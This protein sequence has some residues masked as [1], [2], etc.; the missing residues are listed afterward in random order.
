MIAPAAEA[1]VLNA[2]RYAQ[3]AEYRHGDRSGCLKGTRSTALD[4]IELWTRNFHEPPVYWL[5]GL[6]GTGKTTIAQTVTE[7]LFADGRLGASFFC[8]RD[9]GDRRDLKFIFP[10]LAVQL[11]RKY[12]EFRSILL[13]LIQADPDI[14]HESLYGQMKKLIV[15][16]LMGS[17]IST[18]IV[19]DALDECKDD[20]PASAILSVLGQFVTEIPKVKFFVTGRPEPRIQKSFRLPLL[21]KAT[22]VLVLH[23]VGSGQVNRDIQLF[24]RHNFSEL[25]E[26]QGGLDGWPTEEDLSLLCERAAGFFVYATATIRFV[27]QK[28]KNPKKQLGRLLQSPESGFEGR[29]KLKEGA[30]LDSLYLSILQEAFCDYDPEDGPDVRS[31][32]GAVILATVPLSPSTIAAL[33]GFDA[34][35]VS[36]LLSSAH[37]LLL[38]R[39]DADHPVRPFHKSFP[40][41][42]VDPARC[43]NPKFRVCPSDQHA[44]LL[45]GCLELMNRTLEQNMCQLPDGVTNSEVEDLGERTEQYIDKA[46][47]YACRSWHNHLVSKVPARTLESLHRF[48]TE[49]FLFWLE[50]L[51][52]IGAVREAVDAL[53]ATTRWLDVRRVSLLVR[54]QKFIGPSV[55][56]TNSWP[57]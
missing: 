9:F 4:K 51:S 39:E 20:K 32:L 22:D 40:D 10:T 33:L 16:P 53:E 5:N 21:A 18:V 17:K 54:F 38:F 12:A 47:R 44:E 30:T 3:Q 1:V 14:V 23:E 42:L 8:S 19:I 52:T 56:V 26:H 57:C 6:A 35:D 25:K 37:S 43:T 24:F 27:N 55:G 28:N 46:L 36:P 15:Q 45:F 29:T 49:K 41:F 11:A 48:L 31:V 13:P 34:E 50:V 2:L 7:R